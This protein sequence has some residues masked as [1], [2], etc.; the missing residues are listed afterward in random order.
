GRNDLPRKGVV[1]AFTDSLGRVWFGYQDSRLA[2]LDH[3]RV[4]VFGPDDD[5]QVGTIT[6][7]YGQGPEIW[8]GGEFGLEM[9]DQGRFH[10]IAAAD[11]QWLRGISGIVET[12]NGDLWLNAISGIF[13]IRKAE[14]SKSLKDPAYQVK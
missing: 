6:A 4:R 12:A 13:H 11:A 8:I 5:L 9:F 10:K 2:V 7:I 14:I 1:Y 3:D